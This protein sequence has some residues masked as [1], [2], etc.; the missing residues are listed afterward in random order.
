MRWVISSGISLETTEITPQPPRAISG[1]AMASSPERTRKS[2][3]TRVQYRGHLRDASRCFLDADDV[4]D[5]G[6]ALYGWRLD[7]HTSTASHAVKNDGQGGGA[8]DRAIVLVK[9]F[10]GRLVVVGRDGKNA[11]DA[12]AASSP[13]SAITSAVL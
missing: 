4:I 5:S 2:S 3:G 8:R 9:T 1:R 7:V 6:E 10:L 13:A 11:V 12:D